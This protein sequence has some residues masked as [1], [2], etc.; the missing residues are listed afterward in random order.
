MLEARELTKCFSSIPAVNNVTFAIRPGE[1]LGYLGPN[2]S[3]KSTTVKM[4]TAL[5]EPTRGQVFFEG[6]SIRTDLV[7]Y[8]RRVGY[9]PEEP[10]LY[11]HLSGFEYLELVGLL[12]GLP[13]LT[14]EAK[15][16]GFLELFSLT[17]AR[18][19]PVASYSKG[20]RQKLLLSAA[21][22]HDPDILVLD[23]PDSG[24][25]VTSSLVLRKLVAAL[26][27][28]GKIVLYSSHI[29]EIVEKV[30]SHV[31]VLHKGNVVGYE[32]IDNMR[33]LAAK[34]SLEHVFAQLTEQTDTDETAQG[35]VE[36]MRLR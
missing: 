2:G 9:V 10:N 32:S 13:R 23:E 12:R 8:K 11:P 22:L 35:L 30:C 4:L 18:H 7:A 21:L 34:P 27:A 36:V 25:D 3:G 31:L 19:A 6:E 28:E 29:L 17:L 15:I 5:L 33:R 26:S 24:L 1:V 16:R 14:L 20:M